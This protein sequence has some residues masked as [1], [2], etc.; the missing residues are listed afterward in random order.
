MDITQIIQ[1]NILS[2]GMLLDGTLNWPIEP[3]IQKQWI[4][5][6]YQISQITNHLCCAPRSMRGNSSIFPDKI[7]SWGCQA[8]AAPRSPSRSPSPPTRSCPTRCW[9]SP[10]T[11]P[12]PPYSSSPQRSSKFLQQPGVFRGKRN[13][14]I[15]WNWEILEVGLPT[16]KIWWRGPTEW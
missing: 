10:T 8:V 12:S 5:F 6:R 14:S 13:I 3:S 1:I 16:F 9:R 2:I 4:M 11:L 7:P 15:F